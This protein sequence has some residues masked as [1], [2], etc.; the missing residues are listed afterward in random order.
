MT[1]KSPV[2]H[3]VRSHS[4]SG[5]SV[6][7]YERGH[8]K[9]PVITNVKLSSR[10]FLTPEERLRKLQQLKVNPKN[11]RDWVEQMWRWEHKGRVDFNIDAKT[12]LGAETSYS[13]LGWRTNP[14]QP[15]SD[16]IEQKGLDRSRRDV[17]KFKNLA[18][19]NIYIGSGSEKK[20]KLLA[21][22]VRRILIK[23]FTGEENR[24][25]GS[26]FVEGSCPRVDALGSNAGYPRYHANFVSIKPKSYD[27][28]EVIT[29]ELIHAMRW[30]FGQHSMDRNKEEKET[31]LETICRIPK[32][33][34]TGREFWIGGYYLYVPSIRAERDRTKR[35]ELIK[36]AM[37][38]DRKVIMGSEDAQMKGKP[39]RR[40]IN[41]RRF[42]D[43][44]MSKA[45]FSPAELLDRYFVVLDQGLRSNVHIRYAKPPKVAT[46]KKEFVQEYGK[47]VKVW[48]YQDGKKVKFL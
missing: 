31:E 10:Y 43:T 22:H 40:R 4:R 15:I 14:K 45:H 36:K 21:F 37:L 18:G 35:A 1:R 30:G 11:R 41:S 25:M 19:N 23:Q 44:E 29:H 8:G 46:I 13:Y 26:V 9:A 20:R 3:H 48:E 6:N 12:K 39:L 24:A 17:F 28:D 16:L 7:K 5:F 33:S 42:F 2:H 27:D 32:H 47:G 34:I 38:H